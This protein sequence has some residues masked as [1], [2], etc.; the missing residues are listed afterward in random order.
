MFCLPVVRW[1]SADRCAHDARFCRH[2]ATRW[3]QAMTLRWLIKA[4]GVAALV[5]HPHVYPATACSYLHE[6]LDADASRAPDLTEVIN[7]Q[8]RRGE[9]LAWLG[10]TLICSDKGAVRTQRGN[11]SR[12]S[13]KH[14]A[15][16]GIVQVRPTLSAC[17]CGFRR[18]SRARPMPHRRAPMRYPP[19]AKVASQG[20]KTLWVSATLA[21]ASVCSRP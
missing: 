19:C 3:A 15:S 20:L 10:V 18:S 16:G 17:Q 8:H 1:L 4:T 9:P 11:H 12:R 7:Q 21:L 2:V 13:C 5:C 14:K 6:A